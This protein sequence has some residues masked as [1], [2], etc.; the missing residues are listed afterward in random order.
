[1][2]EFKFV[3]TTKIICNRVGYF[4]VKANSYEEALSKIIGGINGNLPHR[5]LPN[6]GYIEIC[7]CQYNCDYE[8]AS[9]L[10]EN[11]GSGE[12]VFYEKRKDI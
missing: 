10:I 2:E 11:R 1:M 5:D 12:T 4:T 3:E 7:D 6:N 8:V 9:E